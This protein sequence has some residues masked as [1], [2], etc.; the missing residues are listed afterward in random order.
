MFT[1]TKSLHRIC[2]ILHFHQQCMKVPA[3]PASLIYCQ[4]YE[5]LPVSMGRKQ[6][7]IYTYCLT[8]L[9]VKRHNSRKEQKCIQVNQSSQANY[10]KFSTQRGWL[11]TNDSGWGVS[12]GTAHSQSHTSPKAFTTGDPIHLPQVELF[13]QLHS[14]ISNCI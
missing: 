1:L 4:A 5:F 14:Q 3:S 13:S 12:S 2:N 7:L 8:F 9:K 6:H 11:S 10:R